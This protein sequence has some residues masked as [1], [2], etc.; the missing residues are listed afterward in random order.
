M[1]G[2]L[3]IL[4]VTVAVGCI[5][6]IFELRRR[7]RDKVIEDRPSVPTDTVDSAEVET[8]ADSA[9]EGHDGSGVCCGMHLVCE[10]DTLSPVDDKIVYYDDEELDR[11]IGRE[12]D[13]YQPDEIDEFQEVLITMRPEDVVGWARS[14]QLRGIILPPVVHD[15]LL[16]L[17]N[18]QRTNS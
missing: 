15:E 6:Y 8:P 13:S 10:K 2:A 17:V 4:A 16:M 12:A 18:E 1:K 5:L 9:A 7:L 14:I 3:I 11:F